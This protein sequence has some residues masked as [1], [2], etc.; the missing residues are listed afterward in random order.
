MIVY[1]IGVEDKLGLFWHTVYTISREAARD[2]YV[3]IWVF[4]KFEN[5]GIQANV[6]ANGGFWYV[7]MV[8]SG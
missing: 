4:R 5:E 3:W 6:Q 8:L 7:R 1:E 2:P